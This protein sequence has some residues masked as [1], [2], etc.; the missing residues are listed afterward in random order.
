MN[1]QVLCN[2]LQLTVLLNHH[3]LMAYQLDVQHMA[4]F[5]MIFLQLS[6]ITSL[7]ILQNPNQCPLLIGNVSSHCINFITGVGI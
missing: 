3:H 1:W 7:N 2:D 4:V 5:I 6:S